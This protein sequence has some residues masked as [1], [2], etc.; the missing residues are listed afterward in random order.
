MLYRDHS[1]IVRELQ[2]NKCP[3]GVYR[4]SRANE[5]ALRRLNKP[6]RRKLDKDDVLRNWI[7]KQLMK[8]WSPEQISGV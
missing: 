4:A 7:I 2:R 1:V 5:R 3:D 6:H 8:G